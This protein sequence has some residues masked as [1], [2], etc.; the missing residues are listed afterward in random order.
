MSINTQPEA[1]QVWLS[2]DFKDPYVVIHSTSDTVLII[3]E[4]WEP[5]TFKQHFT[6][7]RHANGDLVSDLEI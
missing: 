4:E 5:H 6:I 2:N 1:G 7:Y 3:D